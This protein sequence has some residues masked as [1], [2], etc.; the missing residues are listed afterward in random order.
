[1]K[2]WRQVGLTLMLL[3]LIA[4]T[5]SAELYD[6]NDYG[7]KSDGVFENAPSIQKAIDAAEEAGGGVVVFPSGKYRT[8]TIFLK[9]NVTLRLEKGAVI[10]GT[11][12]Y[13]LYP[14]DI[15]PV[16]ETFLLRKD[17]YAPRVLIVALEKENIAIEGEGVIDGNG[18]EPELKGK[19][20]LASINLI[21]FIKCKNVRVEGTGSLARK[22]KITNAAHWALQPIGV[23]GL[24]VKN[25]HIHNYGGETPDGLAICDSQNVLVEDC[26]IES[27]DDALTLKSGTPD[28]LIENVTVRNST[29]VSRVWIHRW[30]GGG[31]LYH[32]KHPLGDECFLRP[33]RRRILGD[34]LARETRKRIPWQY[35][36]RHLPQHRG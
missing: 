13:S 21:R 31:E 27:D 6:V 33:Y 26:R 8:A 12:D 4:G 14:A 2:R 20:R 7:A 30:R 22:L 25:V 34:L 17:R 10:K 5:S 28:V 36:E 9:D 18:E 11:P 29:L 16:Y 1:M 23:D 24:T 32:A 19:K 35:P 3:T 15:E